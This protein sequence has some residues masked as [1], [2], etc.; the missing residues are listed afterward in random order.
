VNLEQETCSY[1]EHKDR[2]GQEENTQP[3][4]AFRWSMVSEC[5]HEMG[6]PFFCRMM[7][8]LPEKNTR[9]VCHLTQVRLPSS[10]GFVMTCHT[11][12][13]NRVF[14]RLSASSVLHV[15]RN[16]LAKKGEHPGEKGG[17]G[18]EKSHHLRWRGGEKVVLKKHSCEASRWFEK[19]CAKL[20]RLACRGD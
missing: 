3:G 1:K 11:Q 18:W 19:L 17:D 16:L 9:L 15:G 2:T 7:R 10:E 13:Q 14:S 6:L 20:N 8:I 5:F 12:K 4:E